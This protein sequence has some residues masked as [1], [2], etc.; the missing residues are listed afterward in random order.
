MRHLKKCSWLTAI[1]LTS[2][3][4]MSQAQGLQT[5]AQTITNT[6]SIQHGSTELIMKSISYYSAF[7]KW[8]VSNQTLLRDFNRFKADGIDIVNLCVHWHKI[9]NERGE[10]NL[11]VLDGIRNAIIV[12]NEAGLKARI[13]MQYTWDSP[14]LTP[15]YVID[16]FTGNNWMLAILRGM[17]MREAFLSM[18]NYTTAYLSDSPVW[19]WTILGEPWYWPRTLPPPFNE[20]DQKENTI[21]LMQE[22]ASIVRTNIGDTVK[23]DVNF[24]SAHLF[25]RSDGSA[26]IENLFENDWRWD[27]RIFQT[28]DSISFTYH[29]LDTLDRWPN[30]TA[31]YHMYVNITEYNK[32]QCQARGKDVE[33]TLG[34]PFNASN[35]S[36][37]WSKMLSDISN[38][39]LDGLCA[40][41]WRSNDHLG[42]KM[43]LCGNEMGDPTLEY[44][45]FINFQ[46]AE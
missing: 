2:L 17:D 27:D 46:K 16:P 38:Q 20:I 9:E 34:A 11:K 26:G 7:D 1:L 3:L 39:S 30:D 25:T 8:D 43:N 12:A 28:L 22:L 18:Y 23:V 45:Q 19:G 29:P 33:L 4:V 32:A 21:T 42:Q 35:N 24:V 37:A 15:D 41:Y 44:F 36:S 13:S 5:K 40:Y 6:G 31:A 10:Y 14:G